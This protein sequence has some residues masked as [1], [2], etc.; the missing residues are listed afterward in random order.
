MSYALPI[1]MMISLQPSMPLILHL[2][3]FAKAFQHFATGEAKTHQ[4][5]TNEG[6]RQAE[7]D[8]GKMALRESDEKSEEDWVQLVQTQSDFFAAF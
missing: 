6:R 4:V 5:K 8:M 3:K 7:E 1:L 2:H